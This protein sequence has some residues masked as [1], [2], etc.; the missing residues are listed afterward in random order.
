VKDLNI[1]SILFRDGDQRQVLI[2]AFANLMPDHSLAP[3]CYVESLKKYP[4]NQLFIRDMHKFMYL[5]GI[6][7]VLDSVGKL[8]DFLRQKMDHLGGDKT[9]FVGNSSGGYAAML[10]GILTQP[11]VVLAFAPRTYLNKKN[12]EKH[13]DFRNPHIVDTV[14]QGSRKYRAR[15]YLDLKKLNQRVRNHK[16]GFHLFWDRQYRI[17]DINASRMQFRNYFHH[18]YEQGGHMIAKY[19]RDTG[20]F[21]SILQGMLDPDNS[22]Q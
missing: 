5:R 21:D 1:K 6:D 14:A 11:D 22:E 18:P 4:V 13:S 15:K 7:P 8:S 17:D 3:F 9:I 12:R 10:Y 2:V 16:T 20:V 19:L